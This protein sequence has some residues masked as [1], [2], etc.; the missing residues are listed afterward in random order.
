MWRRGAAALGDAELIALILGTGVRARPAVEVAGDL[1][2]ASGGLV[3]LARARR[4]S[5]RR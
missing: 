4:A 1:V 2:R 5:S 3:A